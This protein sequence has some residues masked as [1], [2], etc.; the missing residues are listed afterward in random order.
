MRKRWLL[1]V[2]IL[3]VGVSTNNI[4]SVVSCRHFRERKKSYLEELLQTCN[5]YSF[6]YVLDVVILLQIRE[7]ELQ[8]LF[9]TSVNLGHSL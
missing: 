2:P 9:Y 5:L 6:L 7:L 3:P 1:L 8:C 4:V